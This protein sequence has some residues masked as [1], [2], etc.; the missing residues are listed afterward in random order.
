MIE[1]PAE[2]DRMPPARPVELLWYCVLW[3]CRS[4]GKFVAKPNEA[5]ELVASEN[6]MFGGHASTFS[7]VHCGKPWPPANLKKPLP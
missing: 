3:T 7:M 1:F 2:F 4:C 5:Y 6:A